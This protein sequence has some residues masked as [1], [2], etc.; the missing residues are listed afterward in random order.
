M[1]GFL[2]CCHLHWGEAYFL[3]SVM[4]LIKL[5]NDAGSWRDPHRAPPNFM[6]QVWQLLSGMA[7]QA[8]F[9]IIKK[10]RIIKL[11]TVVLWEIKFPLNLELLNF[12]FSLQ[13]KPVVSHSEKW[14]TNA[15]FILA[16][17]IFS[18]NLLLLI[19]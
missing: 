7:F 13:A 12:C 14:M 10:V 15:L 11:L 4:S 1:P 19:F 3:T 8:V 2:V 5:L 9:Y 18:V 6:V 16:E 17:S